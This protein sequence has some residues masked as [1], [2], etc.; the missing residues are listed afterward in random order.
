MK[1][2]NSFL[3]FTN[4]LKPIQ[5][6]KVENTLNK[7]IQYNGIVYKKKEFILI[8][9]QEGYTPEKQENYKYYSTRLEGYTKPKTL[10]TIEKDNLYNE[11]SK[12]EYD[13]AN[14]LIE[15]NLTN[16]D[17]I[18]NCITEECKQEQKKQLQEEQEH[19]KQLEVEAEKE[20]KKKDF[21]NW[22]ELELTK[23]NNNI[24]FE[25]AKEIFLSELNEY[26]EHQLKKLLV[27][28]DNINIPEVK[29]KLKSWLHCGNRTS[30]K[31]FFHITGIKLP[32]TDK[33]T[34]EILDSINKNNY[35]GIVEYKKRESHNKDIRKFY[36]FM[37]TPESHFEEAEGEYINKYDLDLFITNNS[38]QWNVTEG[39][40]GFSLLSG[41]TKKDI[42][43]K[44]SSIK[45][46]GKL[47][48]IKQQIE[49]LIK[50]NGISPL[51]KDQKAV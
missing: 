39:T 36:K 49:Y 37:K 7:F 26:N 4:N 48:L 17:N 23:Y 14:Y 1:L 32:P 21:E 51:Y 19:Q 25:L 8:K 38:K 46:D 35:T 40:T 13:F 18:M 15:N 50:Q 12:T 9:L 6:T 41:N 34:H 28:I 11:I 45:N 30:K 33:G 43:N 22:L 20:Q 24:N 29:E 44:L 10:Y 5:K 3:G 31:V 16:N 27:L 42:L 47:D 2:Q